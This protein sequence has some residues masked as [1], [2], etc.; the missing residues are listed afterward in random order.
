MAAYGVWG[1]VRSNLVM[2]TNKGKNGYTYKKYWSRL[3]WK[4]T[5]YK[6]QLE[7]LS[8]KVDVDLQPL[9]GQ[10][11]MLHKQAE[12]EADKRSRPGYTERPM[13][14]RKWEIASRKPRWSGGWCSCCSTSNIPEA[15]RVFIQSK[16]KRAAG[17][18]PIVRAVCQECGR[19]LGVVW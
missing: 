7:Y 15:D 17:V 12:Q 2:R 10:L 13:E 6:W 9:I 11:D 1:K 16:R 4:T 5:Q 8:D 3:Q 18:H 19:K 14:Q